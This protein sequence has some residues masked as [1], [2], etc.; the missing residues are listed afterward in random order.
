M[1][2]Q[3]RHCVRAAQQGDKLAME[4]LLQTF[5]HFFRRQADEFNYLS[6]E[7]YHQKRDRRKIKKNIVE[8]NKV[9]D[10]PESLMASENDDPEQHYS[11]EEIRWKTWRAIGRLPK[12][13]RK[14]ICLRYF[15]GY[16]YQDIAKECGMSKSSVRNYVNSGTEKL[17]IYLMEEGLAG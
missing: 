16:S 8:K 3:M 4:E 12:Q 7:A 14:I 1:T 10:L 17:K 13:H 15:H 6:R 5:K 11:K 9:T 2:T